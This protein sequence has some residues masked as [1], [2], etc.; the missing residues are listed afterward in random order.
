MDTKQFADFEKEHNLFARRYGDFFYWQYIRFPLSVAIYLQSVFINVSPRQEKQ[1]AGLSLAPFFYAA[2]YALRDLMKFCVKRPVDVIVIDEGVRRLIDGKSVNYSIDFHEMPKGVTSKKVVSLYNYEK[3]M[4]IEDETPAA[5]FILSAFNKRIHDMKRKT[6][7]QLEEERFLKRLSE[8][9]N[10]TFGVDL[11]DAYLI[12]LINK[13]LPLRRTYLAYYR[14]LFKKT[15]PKLVTLVEYYRCEQFA[16]LEAARELNIPTAEYQ[17]GVTCEHIC[18]WYEDDTPVGKALPDY[19]LTYGEWFDSL[20]KLNPITKA[21][22]VGSPYREHQMNMY[23]STPF[24]ERAVVFYPTPAAGFEEI[25]AKSA[26]LLCKKGY[27]AICKLH[28]VECDVWK[29]RYSLLADS[30]YIEVIDDKTASVYP[31]IFMARH[32]VLADTTVAYE[33][34]GVSDRFIYVPLGVRHLQSE[35]FLAAQRAEGFVSP[36]QLV[37]LIEKKQGVV[38]DGA[39]P[40]WSEDAQS[41]I[42]RFVSQMVFESPSPRKRTNVRT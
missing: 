9:I 26:E 7:R 36:E 33:I 4:Q 18:Y 40:I 16:A 35:P 14:K 22:P 24:D 23:K 31:Y 6:E 13:Y 27:R 37:S 28:P 32:H 34:A 42:Q 29:S 19:M 5:A 8:E 25:I 38:A 10:E 20:T 41:N 17:H 1:N 39:M 12:D 21:V 15:R 11:A 3:G 2:L 30:E